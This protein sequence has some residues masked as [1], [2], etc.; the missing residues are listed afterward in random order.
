MAKYN[1]HTYINVDVSV[2]RTHYV[3]SDMNFRV[4][5]VASNLPQ[6]WLIK[7]YYTPEGNDSI[8]MTSSLQPCKEKT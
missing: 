3:H 5:R 4:L 7:F 2:L 8:P 1:I 6:L